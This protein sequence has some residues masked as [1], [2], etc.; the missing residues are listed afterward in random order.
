MGFSDAVKVMREQRRLTKAE[1][2]QRTH[3]LYKGRR[4]EELHWVAR[5]RGECKRLNGF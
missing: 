5:L 4:D 2:A 3:T 1:L